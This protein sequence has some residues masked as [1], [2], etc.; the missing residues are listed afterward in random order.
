MIAFKDISV[1][2]SS[3]NIRI[4]TCPLY[5]A[6]QCRCCSCWHY[7]IL[8][9]IMYLSRGKLFGRQQLQ[10]PPYDTSVFPTSF[11]QRHRSLGSSQR[12]ARVFPLRYLVPS[13]DVWWTS[14]RKISE[15]FGD[16]RF[17]LDQHASM[18]GWLNEG[19]ARDRSC[20][21]GGSA[22]HVVKR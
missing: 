21:E 22:V 3:R 10:H 11:G 18:V 2:S 6:W 1:C 8:T 17:R 20:V 16:L 19:V 13:G 14:R 4:S 12:P 15:P 9:R 7:H 5:C